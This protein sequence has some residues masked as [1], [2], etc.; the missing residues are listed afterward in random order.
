M[1]TMTSSAY[2]T[3][4]SISDEMTRRAIPSAAKLADQ[5]YDLGMRADVD[6]T[7]RPRRGSSTAA[8]WA[9]QR[10]NQGLLLVAAR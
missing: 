4:S 7:G 2:V 6:A 3:T 5:A 9:N 10:V 8:W 1:K